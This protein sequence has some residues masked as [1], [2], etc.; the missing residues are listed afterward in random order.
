MK[1]G[2]YQQSKWQKNMRYCFICQEVVIYRSEQHKNVHN[3]LWEKHI[4]NGNN[5]K[6]EELMSQLDEEL[7]SK[8]RNAKSPEEVTELLD[9]LELSDDQLEAV[10][11]GWGNCPNDWDSS[12]AMYSSEY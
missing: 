1:Y 8:F 9:G 10:A 7:V 5:D 12:A 3:G 11:G 6:L 2:V 4:M